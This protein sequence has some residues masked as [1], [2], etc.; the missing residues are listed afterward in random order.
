MF[1][2]NSPTNSVSENEITP[3]GIKEK[4]AAILNRVNN[5]ETENDFRR[6]FTRISENATN[7]AN[8]PTY[9]SFINA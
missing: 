8:N 1:P 7:A 9:Q 3:Q 4:T 6:T 5:P 2:P